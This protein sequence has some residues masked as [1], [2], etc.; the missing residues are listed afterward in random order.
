LTL[1]PQA[2]GSCTL[3]VSDSGSDTVT[4]SATVTTLSVPVQ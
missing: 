1:T 4:I 2:A 3:T